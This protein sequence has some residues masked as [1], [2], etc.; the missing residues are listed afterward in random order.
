VKQITVSRTVFTLDELDPDAREKAIQALRE[1]AW[2]TL[3]SD[4]VA[5]DLAG[6]FIELAT[7]EWVGTTSKNTLKDKYGIRIYWNFGYSQGDHAYIEGYLHRDDTPNLAW[8]EN[9]FY[10]NVTRSGRDWATVEYVS[11]TDPETGN[12]RDHYHG[13]EYAATV[14]MVN[15]L[16]KQLYREVRKLVEGY[17]SEDYVLE[18]YNLWAL[19]RRF[20]VTGQFAPPM[21]WAEV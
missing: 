20:D 13:D 15:N 11:V 2:E 7:G 5:E 4:M 19:P 21:F 14:E 16:N 3:D 1:D 9:V 8:P 6:R 18:N 17:T 10:A 12:E